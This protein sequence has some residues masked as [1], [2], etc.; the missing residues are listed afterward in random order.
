MKLRS[1][2]VWGVLLLVAAYAGA[3]TVNTL[4]TLSR[5]NVW[6][7]TNT[8]TQGKLILG[9]SGQSCNTGSFMTGFTNTFVPVCQVVSGTSGVNSLNGLTGTLTLSQGTNITIVQTDSSH[10]TISASGSG[11]GGGSGTVSAGQSYNI[12]QY[13]NSSSTTVQPNV[14]YSIVPPALTSSQLNT[15]IASFGGPVSLVLPNGYPEVPFTNTNTNGVVVNDL[16]FG[17]NYVQASAYGLACD[18]RQVTAQT[19]SGSTTISAFGMS[20]ADVGKTISF[21]G[22]ISGSQASFYPTIVSVNSGAN[23]AVISVSAPFTST[24][25]NNHVT[26]GTDNTAAIQNAFEVVSSTDALLLPANC[27]VLT[28]PISWDHQQTVIG[29]NGNQLMNFIGFPGEDVFLQKDVSGGGSMGGDG[30]V[31][32]NFQVWVDGSLDATQPIIK[33]DATGAQTTFAGFNRPAAPLTAASNNPL[34]PGWA[35]GATNGVANTT[36][37]SALICVPNTLGRLPVT[38]QKIVFPN[39]PGVFTST[40]ASTAGSCTT[41][42]SPITMSAALPNTTGYTATQTEWV[43]STSTQTTTVAIP[44]TVTYPFTLTVANSTLRIPGYES[45]VATHGR[46]KVGIYEFDYVGIAA[47]SL[48]LVAGPATT[49]G[50]ATGATVVPYNP[51]PLSYE[52]PWPVVPDLNTNNS[53]PGGAQYFPAFCLGNAG[54]ALP[55]R[56]AYTYSANASFYNSTVSN[57]NVKNWPPNDLPG[58]QNNNAAWY[59]AGNNKPYS[60]KFD[61]LKM[62]GLAFGLVQGPASVGQHNIKQYGPTGA[63]NKYTNCSIHAGYPLIFDDFQN[64]EISTCDTY[65]SAYAGPSST[66]HIGSATAL[67]MAGTVDENDGTAITS[68]YNIDVSGWSGEPENGSHNEIPIYAEIDCV[69]C[70]FTGNNFEGVPTI[71]GGFG[72]L[73]QGGEM[74]VPSVNYGNNTSIQNV[75]NTVLNGVGTQAS[76]TGSTSVINWG[77]EL[78]MSSPF[79]NATAAGPKLWDSNFVRGSSDGQTQDYAYQGN[80]TAPVVDPKGGMIYPDE[81]VQFNSG[82]AG[83]QMDIAVAYDATSKPSGQS[84]GCSLS[85][86][87]FTANFDGSSLILIG[88]QQRI[89]ADMTMMEVSVKSVAG[90]TSVG[91][92]VQAGAQTGCTGGT[93]FNSSIPVTT[94]WT[95]YETIVDFTGKDACNLQFLIQNPGTG[96]LFGHFNFIPL[97]SRY[98]LRT[99]TYTAG[100]SCAVNGSLLGTDGSNVYWCEGNVVIAQS[101]SGGGGGGGGSTTPGGASGAIQYNNAN[102]FGGLSGT[103]LVKANGSSAPTI[104]AAGTDYVIP[105]GNISGTAAGLSGTPALPNGTTATT[106]ATS[107]NTTKVATTAW[108]KS[109]GLT[110]PLTTLGDIIYGGASGAQTRLAGSTSNAAVILSQTGTGSVSA[111]PTWLGTTGTG[112]VA[113]QTS[114]QFTTPSLGV[115]TGTQI[116]LAGPIT[117]LAGLGTA[118]YS[119]GATGQVGT[120]A[121]APVCV[122]NF[123]CDSMTGTFTFTTGTGSLTAGT[124]LTVTLPGSRGSSGTFNAPTCPVTI[125]QASGTATNFGVSAVPVNTSGTVTIPFKVYTALLPSVAY[126]LTYG[127]CG[128]V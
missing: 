120:S 42:F 2:I 3:Q 15:L 81:F 121:T 38:G 40:V 49:T 58:G 18:A 39:L 98:L 124:I 107:D 69:S 104:A 74:N 50:I 21:I 16:R 4:P 114:P 67:I 1:N 57:V 11:G 55:T 116:T 5:N 66:D 32:A 61:Q 24:N 83:P 79:G 93:L 65:T 33:V 119:L 10:L 117:G 8:F 122:T 9:P 46:V 102:A 53:T 89:P 63:G 126:T 7:G 76:G 72:N 123:V 101:M 48:R 88:N 30:S 92:Q 127:M 31:M 109:L 82:Y 70:V 36:Q 12:A 96:V 112:L 108:V 45:N 87:C 41:G 110:N 100:A 95:T 37:N 19:T 22:V 60:S 94:S 85:G 99:H 54:F 91:L 28:H 113:L 27:N 6:T 115:A 47:N 20:S 128:G 73:F 43:S 13:S 52:S 59:F 62:Y 106:Q 64:G 78:S 86:G 25:V 44:T 26:L 34:A 17:K 105:T 51:C 23:T 80:Y 14:G 97:P 29:Q 90:A 118:T 103:G 75:Q 71:I 111:A 35:V 125:A 84:I 77:H 56:N 68:V